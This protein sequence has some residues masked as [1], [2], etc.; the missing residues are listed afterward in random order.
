MHPLAHPKRRPWCMAFSVYIFRVNG[1][2]SFSLYRT[3][4]R[5]IGTAEGIYHCGTIKAC[6]LYYRVNVS[7]Y[8]RTS[9][10]TLSNRF[11]LLRRCIHFYTLSYSKSHKVTRLIRL[12]NLVYCSTVLYSVASEKGRG[13]RGGN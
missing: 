6:T 1:M 12:P 8:T 4:I 13:V 7:I 9:Y 11:Q 2:E 5:Q 10:Y 3:T